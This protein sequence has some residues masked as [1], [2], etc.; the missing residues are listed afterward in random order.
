MSIENKPQK[1]TLTTE[2]KLYFLII[3]IE[4]I[5]IFLWGGV[6]EVT[7]LS[8]KWGVPSPPPKSLPKSPRGS[9]TRA[10][11]SLSEAFLINFVPFFSCFESI[12]INFFQSVC[13]CCGLMA[14]DT[15]TS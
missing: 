14:G 2:S 15:W 11:T 7:F 3:L 13:T 10:K 6:H 5:T 8:E 9:P 12:F 1:I 4:K